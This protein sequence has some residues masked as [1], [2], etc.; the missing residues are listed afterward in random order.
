LGPS[1]C[2]APLPIAPC[3]P[4]LGQVAICLPFPSASAHPSIPPS[5]LTAA[6][7]VALSAPLHALPIHHSTAQ[8]HAR[9]RRCHRAPPPSNVGPPS[10]G[11]PRHGALSAVRSGAAPLRQGGRASA[12]ARAGPPPLCSPSPRGR[13]GEDARSARPT[14]PAASH[15]TAAAGGS[16][17]V[18]RQRSCCSAGPAPHPM[19]FSLLGGR[20][21][22]LPF[23]GWVGL[24]WV[25]RLGELLTRLRVVLVVTVRRRCLSQK[26]RPFQP[27]GGAP[28]A[29][30][31]FF[32]F[33]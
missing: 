2:R 23:L 1:V 33:N 31:S 3:A 21:W 14:V 22:V 15:R 24:G 11:A 30:S 20:R 26:R 29:Q 18:A 28:P 7:I 9:S 4:S 12:A 16:L 25:G 13:C 6:A 27:H 5:P 8:R 32:F 19:V 17:V 10:T